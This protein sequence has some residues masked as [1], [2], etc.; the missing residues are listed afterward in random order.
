MIKEV[1]QNIPDVSIYPII[2]LT[3]FFLYFSFMLIR[4]YRKDKKTIH[5]LKNLPIDD[6]ASQHNEI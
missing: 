6:D 2:S 4:V 3:V 1:A 5:I